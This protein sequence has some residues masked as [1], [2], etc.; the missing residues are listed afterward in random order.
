MIKKPQ[1]SSCLW[2]L[3]LLLQACI[4]SHGYRDL[5]IGPN[6]WAISTHTHWAVSLAP[7]F[8][9]VRPYWTGHL[10]FF[11]PWTWTNRHINNGIIYP[12]WKIHQVTLPAYP[13]LPWT[14]C[15]F[16]TFVPHFPLEHSSFRFLKAA[17]DV[18]AFSILATRH[19]SLL[20]LFPPPLPAPPSHPL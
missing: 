15:F 3:Q 10:S 12:P 17:F 9:K 11:S 2:P 7:V 6:V 14:L 20:L 8:L 19:L 13:N 5:S 18:L 16:H 4:T 1:P